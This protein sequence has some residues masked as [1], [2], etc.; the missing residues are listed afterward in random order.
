[1]PRNRL[2]PVVLIFVL[3]AAACGVGDD[4]DPS[5]RAAAEPPETFTTS[6]S[7]SEGWHRLAGH[8]IRSSLRSW[9]GW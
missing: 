3:V 7:G 8:V 9:L 2:I 4:S 1:M 6:D 5:D